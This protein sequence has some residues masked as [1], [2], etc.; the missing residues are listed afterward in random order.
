MDHARKTA[1]HPVESRRQRMSP[2]EVT[3]DAAKMD[4]E[5]RRET[6]RRRRAAAAVCY[7]LMIICLSALKYKYIF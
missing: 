1:V 7:A 3:V 4:M 2:P 6:E 5:R